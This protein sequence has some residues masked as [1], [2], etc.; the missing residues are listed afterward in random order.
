M[1]RVYTRYI[2][3]IYRVYTE[4]IQG[5]YRVYTGYIPGLYTRYIQ[6][7]SGDKKSSNWIENKSLGRS[8]PPEFHKIVQIH[9]NIKIMGTWT[10]RSLD[11]EKCSVWVQ[12][13]WVDLDLQNSKK[14]AKTHKHS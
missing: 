4:Y 12:G 14:V 6:D 13:P 11:D 7:I 2:Q 3:G 5:I 9:E 8:R 10:R 1:S